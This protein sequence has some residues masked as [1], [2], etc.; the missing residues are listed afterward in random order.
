MFTKSPVYI[1][2]TLAVGLLAVVAAQVQALEVKL[3]SPGTLA[4]AV[5]GETSA[6][7][8]T[9]S[10]PMDATDFD[11]I[12]ERM[13]SLTAL[14]LGAAEI[15]AYSGAAT[16]TGRLASAANT[17]PECA[18]MGLPL[19][20]LTLPATLQ[21]IEA[22][23]LA[24]TQLST[25]ALP[26]GVRSIGEGA[27]SNSP[28]LTAIVVPEGVAII[29]PGT[30][31]DC[32]A[33]A[34][35]ALPSTLTA[36][37]PRA[38]MGCGALEELAFPPALQ[39]IGAEAFAACGLRSAQ[40]SASKSLEGV[41]EWAFA[42]CGNLCEVSFPASLSSLGK[43][44]FFMDKALTVSQLPT[45]VDRLPDYAFTDTDAQGVVAL[46]AGAT[47]VGDYALAGW[48]GVQLLRLSAALDSIGTHAMAGWSALRE[49]D[50]TM[51]VSVPRLGA[52]VWQGVEQPQVLLAVTK[53]LF[54]LFYTAPQ[55]SEF[56]LVERMNG[57]NVAPAGDIAADALT[58]RFEGTLL[59]VG[60]PQ[61][62]ASVVLYD[63]A[64]RR[65]TLPMASPTPETATIDTAPWNAGVMVV[66]VI[67]ADGSSAALKL[68]R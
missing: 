39:C 31:K 8:L 52:E 32:T 5:G 18:L 34:K 9:V 59:T 61:A 63:M 33:L 45:G 20:S 65:Y 14:D 6:A 54:P 10:G 44:A 2:R 48:R 3:A 13:P 19:T 43:G 26:T 1:L 12:A 42:E 55:W 57:V 4:A 51:M 41:G 40:L 36:I 7:T 17:L 25:V 60:A 37:G 49:I 21:T 24:A 56:K 29:A 15:R 27:F 38:F 11:F 28:K 46:P 50:G 66:H 23:A 64:G 35:V 47:S 22:G 68:S 58:A 62:I 53:E 30:F 16:R 67:L